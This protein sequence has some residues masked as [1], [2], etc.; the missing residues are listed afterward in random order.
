[1][2]DVAYIFNEQAQYHEQVQ[3]IDRVRTIFHGVDLANRYSGCH[4]SDDRNCGADLMPGLAAHAVRDTYKQK[5]DTKTTNAR[6]ACAP[7]MVRM[8]RLAANGC[9]TMKEKLILESALHPLDSRCVG[10]DEYLAD[11]GHLEAA[12]RPPA[13]CP[14][15]REEVHISRMHDRA[16]TPYFSHA[17]GEHAACPLV[18]ST[19]PD[20]KFITIYPPDPGLENRCRGEFIAQW[21][22]H[23]SEIR[24]HVPHFSVIRFTQV[25]AHAD[26]LHLWSSPMLIQ[27][28]IPYILLVLS[29]F[30]AETPGAAHSTWLRFLFDASIRDPTE[31]RRP[32]SNSPH[33]FRLHYRASFSSMFPNARHLLDW[34]EVPMNGD[35]LHGNTPHILMSEVFT[36]ENFIQQSTQSKDQPAKTHHYLE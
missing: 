19:L 10:V 17:A 7:R 25:I 27:E 2:T 12:E 35:F 8:R 22:H 32:G 24:R 36:F 15:C 34:S 29:T 23:L 3:C 4:V 16:R 21:K 20:T 18:N 9:S 33:L 26:V 1:M 11:F 5:S 31:I 30:I 14:I 6:D 28:D 13:H